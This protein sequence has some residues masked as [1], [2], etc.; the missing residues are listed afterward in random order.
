MDVGRTFDT[1]G[2]S[3]V[4]A[5]SRST[6]QTSRMIWSTLLGGRG[7]NEV[8]LS[9]ERLLDTCRPNGAFPLIQVVADSG[10]LLAGSNPVCPTTAVAQNALE[11]TEDLTIGTGRHLATFGVHGE[12]F[13]FRDP[14]VQVSAGRWLFSSLDSLAR[15][16]ANH[17]DRGLGSSARPPGADFRVFGLGLYAQDRWAPTSR[18]TLTGGL[19]LD[20]PFLLDAAMTNQRLVASALGTDTGRLPSGNVLWSPRLGVNYDLSGDG[21]AVLP[22]G[23]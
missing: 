16:L 12:L 2:L 23:I 15:G 19:R 13:H 21:N 18:L 1:T 7:Q 14:L 9:Y 20:V 10:I 6:A 17:Y 5:R 8:I 4:A 11:I 22:G 3:S